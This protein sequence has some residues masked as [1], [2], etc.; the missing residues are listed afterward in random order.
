MEKY[1]K[2]LDLLVPNTLEDLEAD[3]VE[4]CIDS[5]AHR[6]PKLNCDNTFI[7]VCAKSHL[8]VGETKPSE[9][10]SL[11]QQIEQVIV[12]DGRIEAPKTEYDLM[13]LSIKYR[14][15]RVYLTELVQVLSK[16][17]L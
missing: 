3:L 12:L 11:C 17:Y 10:K 15:C 1:I 6:I 9:V 7:D 4:S 14:K 2:H 8:I 5:E 13:S 16:K